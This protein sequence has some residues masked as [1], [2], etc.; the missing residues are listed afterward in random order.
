MT[1]DAEPI[2]QDQ[3]NPNASR[4]PDIQAAQGN[5][6][7]PRT[8]GVP[9]SPPPK[10]HCEISCKHEKDRW[11]KFKDGAEIFGISLLLIYTI[12]TIK[13]Y[14]ANKQAA[15]A[16][17]SAANTAAQAVKDARQQ[18]VNDE[19]PIVWLKD[20][21]KPFH[22]PSN[23]VI[24][25]LFLTNYG[26]TP[27]DD[28]VFKDVS[29][30][31]GENGTWVPTYG[32]GQYPIIPHPVAPGELL[33]RPAVTPP[34][35]SRSEYMALLKVNGSISMRTVLTYTDKFGGHYET[36]FCLTRT[37]IGDATFCEGNYIH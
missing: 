35:I 37:N 2:G 32:T 14:C 27:A 22:L 9:S 16:A 19:R 3:S 28:V 8:P 29:M 25:G 6:D 13:M 23:Q 21:G 33:P 31:I 10:T 1:S 5:P 34:G 17:T 36:A 26:K 24:W 12:Y 7:I 30:R 15:D 11:D 18:F 4:K 20:R